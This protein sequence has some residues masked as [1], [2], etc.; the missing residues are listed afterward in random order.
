MMVRHF[1]SS[2]NPLVLPFTMAHQ[3][4]EIRNRLDKVASDGIRFCL[5]T[6]HV[7]NGLILQSRETYSYVDA[8]DVIGRENDREEIIK[9]LMQPHPHG[10]VDKNI[11]VIPIVGIGGLGKTTLAKLVI[12]DARM[13][14]LFSLKMWVCVSNDFDIK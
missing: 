5:A 10:Y 13:D 3:I 14:Q 4:K 8:L 12:N 2:S 6:N 11:S 9:L 7:D 1:F